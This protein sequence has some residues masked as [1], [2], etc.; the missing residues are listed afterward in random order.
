M[1]CVSCKHLMLIGWKGGSAKIPDHRIDGGYPTAEYIE[2]KNKR[3][4][5][6]EFEARCTKA[7]ASLAR[8]YTEIE[9]CN[10]WERKNKRIKKHHG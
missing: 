5:R 10:Q 6:R 1:I 7:G 4:E 2:W 3:E 9:T 8:V